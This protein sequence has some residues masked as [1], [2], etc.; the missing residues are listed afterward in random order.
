MKL[1]NVYLLFFVIGVF[2]LSGCGKEND[3]P[4]VDSR[5]EADAELPEKDNDLDVKHKVQHFKLD[6]FSKEGKNTWCLEGDFAKMKNDD[7]L[8]D[9]ITGHSQADDISVVLTADDGVYERK[10]GSVKLT[11]NVVIVTSDGGKLTMDRANWSAKSEEVVTDAKVNI[12]HS[13]ITVVAVGGMI[14][15]NTQWARLEKNIKVTDS[16][17]RII[18]CDGPLEVDY[19]KHMA[20]FYNNVIITEDQGKISANKV[21]A[22]F[23]PDKKE[24]VRIE[25][26][27][28]VKAVY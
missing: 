26:V 19:E 8:L 21:I 10:T 16:S 9:T 7:I 28:E 25:W 13:G 17:N 23:D 22:Y 12:V 1:S 5:T 20:T 24:I 3:S 6:G 4:V 18:T 14:K 2:V 27:G 15:P 11:G